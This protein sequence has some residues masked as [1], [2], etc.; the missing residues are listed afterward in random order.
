VRTEVTEPGREA[1]ASERSRI[2]GLLGL[3]RRAGG[4]A[5]GTDAVREAL[6]T[7]RARLVLMAEDASP[8]QG[9]KVRRT[10]AGHPTPHATW[11]RRAELGAAVG[12]PSLSAVAITHPELAAKLL[13]VLDAT[14]ESARGAE[15]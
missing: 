10:L 4:V 9:D 7:G 1:K 12:L 2:T 6:R 3:A 5:T 13:G 14:V 8:A 11:G 15:A